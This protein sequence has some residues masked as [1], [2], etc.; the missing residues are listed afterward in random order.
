MDIDY[1]DFDLEVEQA[2]DFEALKANDF[3]IENFFTDQ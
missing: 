2:V 3:D 1:N